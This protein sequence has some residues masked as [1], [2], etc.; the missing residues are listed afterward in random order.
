MPRQRI[1]DSDGVSI[2]VYLSDELKEFVEERQKVLG[3]KS[4]S[5]Y[6]RLLVEN[7]KHEVGWCIN[8]KSGGV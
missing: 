8:M 5:A 6:I 3:L 2:N 4:K 7:M 1:C